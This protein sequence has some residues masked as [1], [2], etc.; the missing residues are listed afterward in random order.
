MVSVQSMPSARVADLPLARGVPVL[1]LL[2]RFRR[3]PLGTLAEVARRCGP[4]A[5]ARFGRLEF[6][7]VHEPEYIEQVLVVQHHRFVKGRGIEAIRVALGDG[8]LTSEGEL[9]RRQRRLAQ[10]A[11]HRQRVAAYGDTMVAY[12]RRHVEAWRDGEVRDLAAEMARL[13]LAIAAKTLFGVDIEAEATRIG[14]ALDA[15]MQ[16]FVAR[17]RSLLPLPEHW[18]TPTYRRFRRAL[19]E[20]DAIVYGIIE[21]RRAAGEDTG[22]LLSMLMQAVDEDGSGM[23]PRQLRDEALTLLLAGH[24]TTAN[25]L[26]W[27]WYLLAGHPEAAERL[28]RELREVLGDRDPTAD[29]VPRLPYAQ[30][31]IRES[32]RLYPPAWLLGRRS[33]EPFALGPYLFPP[34][35]QVLM[36]QWVVHRDPRFYEEPDAFRPERWLGD[37]PRRLPA[38]A[39]FPFGGGPRRCIGE[40]FALL[41]AVLVLAVVA[42]R[43]RV[44]L[45]PG[46][47]V[48]PEPV[49]TLR[50]KH[51]L[52]VRLVRV[53]G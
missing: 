43:F 11:F 40:P 48:E 4:L 27:T 23:T 17:T 18:P 44:E 36:S 12:A 32:M 29:D 20:L 9:W 39:Y 41:E 34:G 6:L 33:V 30:A 37:L 8:L 53:R 50:L 25:A 38:L 3:D 14:Q 47:R 42:R 13:T 45:V 52:P 5:R 10:P 24:E 51:G 1:G 26:S 31:V 22:D 21:Q 46:A 19:A 2:P 7:L 16:A 15:A 28:R 35:T 49:V